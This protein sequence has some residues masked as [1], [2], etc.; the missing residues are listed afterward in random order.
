MDHELKQ[1]FFYGPQVGAIS[2]CDFRYGSSVVAP[3]GLS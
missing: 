2:I 1:L 3:Y